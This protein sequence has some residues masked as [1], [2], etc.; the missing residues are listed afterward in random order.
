MRCGCFCLAEYRVAGRG[1][2]ALIFREFIHMLFNHMI[3]QNW[4][5]NA[6]RSSKGQFVP[7][8]NAAL[9]WFEGVFFFF[10]YL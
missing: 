9:L 3:L 4:S 5:K 2:A 7:E 10:F 6:S 1:H 8:S